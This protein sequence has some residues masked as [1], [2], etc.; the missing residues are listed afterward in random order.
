MTLIVLHFPIAKLKEERSLAL[1]EK[2]MSMKKLNQ[3][4]LKMYLQHLVTCV[5]IQYDQRC[6]QLR[7]FKR[8]SRVKERMNKQSNTPDWNYDKPYELGLETLTGKTFVKNKL[9]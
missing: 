4:D 1:T 7:K 2:G 9:F 8:W 6:T 5:C 3:T